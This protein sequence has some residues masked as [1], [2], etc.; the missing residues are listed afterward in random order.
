MWHSICVQGRFLSCLPFLRSPQEIPFQGRQL[1]GTPPPPLPWSSLPNLTNLFTYPHKTHD[2]NCNICF[3]PPFPRTST[4]SSEH[5]VSTAKTATELH[6]TAGTCLWM[7]VSGC[8]LLVVFYILGTHSLFSPFP[9]LATQT[10]GVNF[11]L[12]SLLLYTLSIVYNYVELDHLRSTCNME[13]Y[14]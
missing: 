14:A 7:A 1:L 11:I 2:P 9:S 4:V 5:L 12:T 3:W 8:L 13:F 10:T 6:S